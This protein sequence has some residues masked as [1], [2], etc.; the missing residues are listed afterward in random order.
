M[1]GLG[2]T[3]MLLLGIIA[4]ML[5]GSRLP[6]VARSFGQTYRQLR[7][8]VDEFQRE[9][10]EWERLD[11]PPTTTRPVV[12]EDEDRFEPATPKF[13]PPPDE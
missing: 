1:S 4:L 7:S 8:K 11:A 2:Y 5:F 10:R 12:D 13:K 6:E 3:E 9:F